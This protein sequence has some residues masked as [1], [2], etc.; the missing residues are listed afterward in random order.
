MRRGRR[1]A[2]LATIAAAC[3][4]LAPAAARADVTHVNGTWETVLPAIPTG[5]ELSTGHYRAKGSSLWQGVWTGATAVSAEGTI[6]LASGD[7]NGTIHET[8]FGTAKHVGR[9]TLRFREQF[10]IDGTSG[11]FHLVARIKRGTGDFEG[12]SGKVHLDG[13]TLPTGQGAGTY[14]GHWRHPG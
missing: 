13:R 1:I 7:V 14:S 10:T 3:T 4:A 6:S 8:F 5:F 2:A 9:G 12:S 11:A